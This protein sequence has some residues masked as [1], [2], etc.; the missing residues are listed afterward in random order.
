MPYEATT[1]DTVSSRGLTVG[2]SLSPDVSGSRRDGN[3]VQMVYDP[4]SPE[5][6]RP[7]LYYP[8]VFVS[9]QGR[10]RDW[11]DFRKP[12]ISESHAYPHVNLPYEGCQKVHEI[13]AEAWLGPRPKGLFICHRDDNKLDARVECLR[14]D[15]PAANIRDKFRNSKRPVK[16]NNT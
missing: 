9:N 7:V 15:T 1:G 5:L 16:G 3:V 8:G 4:Q 2:F 11:K 14:Y 6:W 12:R 13:V 10:V